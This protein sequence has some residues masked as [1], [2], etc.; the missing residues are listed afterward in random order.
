MN[1]KTLF[2]ILRDLKIKSYEKGETIIREGDSVKD[3]FYI[4]KGIIRCYLVDAKAEEITF[5]L[6]AEHQVFGNAHAILFDEPSKFFF[7]ALEKTKVYSTDLKSFQHLTT[8]HTDLS[9]MNRMNIGR[10]IL[11]NAFQRLESLV[12]L[13]PEERYQKYIEDYPN[14]INRVPDKYIANVLGITPVSLSRI[15][16][17]IASKKKK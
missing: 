4:R 16:S 9:E 1:I 2:K 11:K 15:R 17:R 14:I 3:I 6:F 8:A 5:Q 12:F 7:E 13:T 10:Q